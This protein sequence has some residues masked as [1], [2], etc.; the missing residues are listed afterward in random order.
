[1]LLCYKVWWILL[2]GKGEREE[3]AHKGSQHISN[4]IYALGQSNTKQA[5]SHWAARSGLI[6]NRPLASPSRLQVARQM[7]RQKQQENGNSAPRESP[8]IIFPFFVLNR[9]LSVA[10]VFHK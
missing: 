5:R 4:R 8:P 3:L 7:V 1:M 6:T 9:V 10:S 2:L